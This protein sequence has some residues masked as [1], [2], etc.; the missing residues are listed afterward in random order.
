M[1]VLSHA[2]PDARPANGFAAP[3]ELM[4]DARNGRLFI[5]VDD[6]DSDNGGDL[7]VAG[8]MATPAA[9]NFMARFARGLIC[10]ALTKERVDE[11][12]LP[13]MS[14]HNGRRSQTAF[15]VSI[16][17]RTGVTTGISVA[18]RARTVAVA[19]DGANSR[20]EII[21]PGH[22]FP[23]QAQPG[24]VLVRA[25]HTEASVDIARLAGINP[26]A[27][28]CEIMNGD[29]TMARLPDLR[30]FA[31]EHGFNIGTIRDL[32]AY[33]R[34]YDNLVERID[35]AE[36][37]S[38]FGGAWKLLTYR[39]RVNDSEE[40]V[41][42][43]GAPDS[44]K[45]TLVRM[46][47]VSPMSDMFGAL[48]PRAGLLQRAMAEIGREGCGVIVLFR[49]PDT[50]SGQK[51]SWDDNSD[52]DDMPKTFGI[53]AQILAELDIHNMVLLTNSP[54]RT[55]KGLEAFGVNIV[56]ERPIAGENGENS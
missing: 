46:H 18:D 10:L 55:L 38:R 40:L 29:G 49:R 50:R 3:E 2:T 42:Q 25:G 27:V 9:I 21:T 1:N 26:S 6:E 20:D 28:I 7:V 17:A 32:I 5:L 37:N 45:P 13:A 39:S 31:Q 47:H 8:Q 48:G 11:L 36:F 53:G 23:V 24:G 52:P 54:H 33:R 15:T 56:E 22:V 35:E 16:E 4:N 19:I 12:G 43:K 44:S 41:L 34:R 51:R 30:R 14:R